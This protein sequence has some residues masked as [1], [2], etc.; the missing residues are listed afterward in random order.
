[1]MI[2]NDEASHN[3]SMVKS[4]NG[5]RMRIVDCFTDYSNPAA[6]SFTFYL[7]L[8]G[9]A[10]WMIPRSAFDFALATGCIYFQ[11]PIVCISRRTRGRPHEEWGINEFQKGENQGVCKLGRHKQNWGWFAS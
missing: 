1:M 7:A 3:H 8:I 5:A 2:F 9:V 4:V 10:T 11:L 6:F